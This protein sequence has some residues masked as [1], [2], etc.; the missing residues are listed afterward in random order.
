MRNVYCIHKIPLEKVIV[1]KL[2]FIFFFIRLQMSLH[3]LKKRKHRLINCVIAAVG[4]L[5]SNFK[6]LVKICKNNEQS[7]TTTTCCLSLN[8]RSLFILSCSVQLL[9]FCPQDVILVNWTPVKKMFLR[10]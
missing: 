6:E 10:G 4:W 3:D 5:S 8:N 7:T 1:H 9:I 2:K